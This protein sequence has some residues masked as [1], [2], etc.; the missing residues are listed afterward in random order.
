MRDLLSLTEIK[1]ICTLR[2]STSYYTNTFNKH[3]TIMVIR[4]SRDITLIV[5]A[6]NKCIHTYIKSNRKKVNSCFHALFLPNWSMSRQ[7]FFLYRH[8]YIYYFS[9]HKG[10]IPTS[11]MALV[12]FFSPLNLH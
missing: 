7:I 11:A 1:E 2:S 9:I 12:I 4:I 8:Q 6:Y 3:N 10:A 5:H